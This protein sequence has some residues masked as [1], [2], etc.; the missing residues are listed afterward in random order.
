[1]FE[2][3]K[4]NRSSV[5]ILDGVR[6][7]KVEEVDKNNNMILKYIDSIESTT[8]IYCLL[9][10]EL[11][12]FKI[13]IGTEIYVTDYFFGPVEYRLII[14]IKD[15]MYMCYPNEIIERTYDKYFK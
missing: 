2:Y 9:N 7:T 15:T 12:G 10:E 4:N 11:E 6:Y 13:P 5:F 1:M 14:E 8:N 3:D